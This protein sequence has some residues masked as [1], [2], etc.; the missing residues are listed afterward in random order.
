M[1]CGDAAKGLAVLRRSLFF[2]SWP[3][4]IL[5]LLLP[6]YGRQIGAS[7]VEIG[8]FFSAFSL[9]TVPMRPLIGWAVDR[10]GRRPFFV[11]GLAGYAAT[12]VSFAFI[13]QVWGIVAARLL[14]GVSSSFVWL[15]AYAIVADLS[16]EGARGR[17]FGN[18]IQAS[19]QGSIVG[20]FVGFTL[21]NARLSWGG[22]VH[23]AGSWQLLFLGYALASLVAFLHAL[24]RLPE[25]SPQHTQAAARRASANSPI[26]WS[27]PWMLLLLVTLVT[28]ASWA[29]VS[30]ILVVFLQDKLGVGIDVLSWAFLPYG[31]V[32]ALLPGYLGRLADR[33]GR[34]PM[35]ILGLVMAAVS[36]F[37]IP[38]VSSLVTF[39]ALWALQ[40][41][42][43]AAG[44]PAEQALVADLT[45]GDQRGRAYGLYVLAADLGAT[46]GPVA[47]AWLYQSVSPPA[48]FVAN[49][50]VLA[51]CAGLLAVWLR[52]PAVSPRGGGSRAPA[53]AK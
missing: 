15:T 6:V 4:F 1:R 21:L 49:A 32:W 47:G 34:K 42:C 26:V 33:F 22:Q 53:G 11:L 25:T 38:A 30:P 40:A 7:T 24:W 18:L 46:I 16:A 19:S 14:Q 8:L 27:R 41:L 9:M 44:D 17:A 13:E 37:V 52:V 43:Y 51:L 31:L 35:M 23:S 2:V 5:Y 39:A 10:F 50:A 45:G 29:M 36:S 3:F 12:W 28:G 20:T 48:P